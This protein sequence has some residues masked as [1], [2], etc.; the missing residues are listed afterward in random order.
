M[1]TLCFQQQSVDYKVIADSNINR[2]EEC[3]HNLKAKF[4]NY[5]SHAFEV[6]RPE[7]FLSSQH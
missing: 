1:T 3:M 5:V 6:S 4:S 2:I 7:N